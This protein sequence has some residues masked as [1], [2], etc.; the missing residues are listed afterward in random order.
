MYFLAALMLLMAIGVLVSTV[1]KPR[2]EP[3]GNRVAGFGVALIMGVLGVGIAFAANASVQAE[4]QA[5]EN[6]RIVNEST[7]R[8][9]AQSAAN[10]PTVTTPSESTPV[11]PAPVEPAPTTTGYTD[12][13]NLAIAADR[14]PN[15]SEIAE[16]YARLDALCPDETPS[17]AD[18]VVNLRNIVRDNS[19]RELDLV[20]VLDQ[21]ITA[22]E[23]APAGMSCAETGGALAILMEKGL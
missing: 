20:N 7:A 14:D 8:V 1:R 21:L 16:K 3:V 11:E 13:Q 2:T 15:D 23:G 18:L 19:G 12:V 17:T 9:E 10:S 5:A 22:Q 6:E 4:R